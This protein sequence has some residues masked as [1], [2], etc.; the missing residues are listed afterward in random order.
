VVGVS[1]PRAHYTQYTLIL[2]RQAALCAPRGRVQ[3]DSWLLPC[4]ART[5]QFH[6]FGQAAP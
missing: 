2:P 1:A 4:I 5:M 3:H 6:R